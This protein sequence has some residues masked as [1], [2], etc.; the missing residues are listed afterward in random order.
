VNE[1]KRRIGENE[2]VFRVVNEQIRGLSSTLVNATETMS[3]VCECGTRSCT[4]QFVIRPEEYQRVRD[5]P[6]LFLV[7]PGHDLPETETVV[8][9]ADQY[10]VVRKDPGLPEAIARATDPGPSAA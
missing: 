3:I 9:R 6:T 5:D 8:E 2:A 1:R 7:R 10:W 4:V